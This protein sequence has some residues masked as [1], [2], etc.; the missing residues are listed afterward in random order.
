M[1]HHCPEVYASLRSCIA[2]HGSTCQSANGRQLRVG[3]RRTNRRTT[4]SHKAP[5]CGG[6]L[7]N[8]HFYTAQHNLFHCILNPTNSAVS[9]NIQ[10]TASTTKAL[11]LRNIYE[12]DNCTS[13]NR[14]T[15][16]NSHHNQCNDEYVLS[17]RQF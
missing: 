5:T 9:T 8:K 15:C 13:K 11:A 6:G 7:V 14:I 3:D 10:N 1:Q 17:S 12:H 4:L 16:Y 2:A